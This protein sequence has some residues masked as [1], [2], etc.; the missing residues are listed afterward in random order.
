MRYASPSACQDDG[1]SRAVGSEAKLSRSGRR[2]FIG[3]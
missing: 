1:M 2:N 3:I